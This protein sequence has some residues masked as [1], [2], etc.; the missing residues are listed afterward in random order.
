MNWS[1]RPDE[2]VIAALLHDIGQFLLVDETKDLEM[3]IGGSSVGRI[4]HEKIGEEYLRSLG[5]S[6]N[7]CHIVGSHVAAKRLFTAII[8]W[9]L[10]KFSCQPHAETHSRYLTA[11][12][13]SYY[14]GLSDASKKSLSFQGGPFEGKEL[15]AFECH[16]LKDEMVRVRK[17]DDMSKVVGIISQTPRTA[18]YREMIRKH[19]EKA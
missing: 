6:E 13:S 12:D 11:V 7:V 16:P 1:G 19:L 17:W 2:T 8:A 18:T 4:G 3:S 5:F 14:N 15:E 9:L 10:S